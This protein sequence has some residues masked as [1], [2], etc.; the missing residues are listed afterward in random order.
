[1]ENVSERSPERY[2]HPR[3]CLAAA[4]A[5]LKNP[6]CWTWVPGTELGSPVRLVWALNY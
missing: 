4:A 1:M 3:Q 5:G 6:N 2:C